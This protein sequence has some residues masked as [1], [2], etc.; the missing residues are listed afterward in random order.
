MIHAA[1]LVHET[2]VLGE[3]TAVWQ[4]AH[5]MSGVR[6]GRQCSIG[7]GA[8]LG[9]DCR[10]GDRVRI[11]FGVFL[12]NHT[13]LEDDVFLGPGV[14]ATDDKFPRVNNPHYRA[15]PPIFRRGCAVGAGAVILPGVEIGEGALVGAGAVV[16][17]DVAAYTR[18][19]GTPARELAHLRQGVES[20]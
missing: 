16:T 20:C 11:G 14:I 13:I 8:E 17:H 7:G 9:R 19:A 3:G 12:P 4:F 15:Q 6:M 5:V 1:A 2:A 18:V 10:L